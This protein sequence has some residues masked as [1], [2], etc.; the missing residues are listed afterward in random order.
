MATHPTQRPRCPWCGEDPLYIAYHDKEW[1]VPLHDEHRLFEM[2]I[3]EGA[4]AGLS[5]L[6]IL[7]KR[8]GYREAFSGFDPEK[9][10]R[11]DADVIEE[12]VHDASIVRNR[13]KITAAVQN[14]RAV[15]DLQKSVGSLE[16]YLWRWV[17]GQPIVNNF[18][19]LDE[20]PAETPL[21]KQISKD[22][23]KR[24]FS[25]VGPTIVYAFMQAVGIVDDHLVSCWKRAD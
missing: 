18:H 22:L 21:S 4:Q 5:W 20:V 14:A 9:V 6:T 3:L 1:G 11:Y 19:S 2:L 10:A 23:K 24:G 8:E 12:L 15:L 16:A 25:F 13:Q 17:D 7:K